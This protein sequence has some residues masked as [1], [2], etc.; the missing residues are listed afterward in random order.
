MFTATVFVAG[1]IRAIVV[2][3]AVSSRATLTG[4]SRAGFS[5]RAWVTVIAGCSIFNTSQLTSIF[6]DVTDHHFTWFDWNLAHTVCICEASF[7]GSGIDSIKRN[8]SI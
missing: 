4:L 7:S 3:I 8:T 6:G 2:V 5:Y 1:V